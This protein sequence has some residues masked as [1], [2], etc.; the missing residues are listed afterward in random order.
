MRV[1]CHITLPVSIQPPK[2]WKI[3]EIVLAD[4]NTVQTDFMVT[5]HFLIGIGKYKNLNEVIEYCTTVGRELDCIRVKVEQEDEFH[6]P[7]TD[8]NYVEF[9]LKVEGNYEMKDWA[10]SENPK[11]KKEHGVSFF[12]KRVRTG[13]NV[14]EVINTEIAKI[15]VPYVELKVEHVVYDSNPS[16][17]AWWG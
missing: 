12:S 1:H 9:H 16:C 11:E 4:D 7:V 2:G 15:K 6:L 10:R 13:T 5:K 17:D 14:N 3:T 8:D